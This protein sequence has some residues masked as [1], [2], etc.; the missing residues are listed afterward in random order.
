MLVY[1]TNPAVWIVP[2][3][4]CLIVSLGLGG[5]LYCQ[6]KGETCGDDWFPQTFCFLCCLMS[7]AAAYGLGVGRGGSP[8]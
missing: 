4:C 2:G 7:L 3:L 6:D 1:M 8:M 5:F